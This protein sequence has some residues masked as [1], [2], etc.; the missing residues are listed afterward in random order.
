[1]SV[2]RTAA[3]LGLLAEEPS[4]REGGF[5]VE[6]GDIERGID[7]GVRDK[8]KYIWSDCPDCGMTKWTQLYRYRL[9]EYL[10]CRR[11]AAK[12]SRCCGSNHPNWR[13]GF[14]RDDG[15]VLIRILPEDGCY[16]MSY[17][18]SILEHRYI[19]AK[20]LGRCLTNKE[21]VHH[22]NGVR[23]D[24]R[25]ENIA[26]VTKG[27]HEHYTFVKV[28]QSRILELERLVIE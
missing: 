8:S 18:G 27:N 10:R 14:I 25:P 15:Y 22:L 7:I 11:C 20:I 24:N 26:I 2:S 19:M 13:G 17:G 23:D 9:G 21:I 4:T 1:M 12:T 3:E 5:V 28:M 6:I 16:N